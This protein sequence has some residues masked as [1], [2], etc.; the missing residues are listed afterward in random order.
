MTAHSPASVIS[1]WLIESGVFTAPT[2][3]DDWPVY[4]GIM[5]DGRGVPDDCAAI[6]DS[7]GLKDGRLM[8]SG[9]N[10]LHHGI[11]IRLRARVYADGWEKGQEITEALAAATLQNQVVLE[12][13][14]YSLQ[15]VS[16][17]ETLIPVG[18]EESPPRR[19][20]FTVNYL[21]TLVEEAL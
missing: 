14:T 21:A 11:Q 4:I 7:P 20:L 13:Y 10:I 2:D 5:P 17:Q 18:Y 9:L 8:G 19:A 15:N 16:Q 6:Y 12:G 3:N 1:A